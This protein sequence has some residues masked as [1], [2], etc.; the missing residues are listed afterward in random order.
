MIQILK[1]NLSFRKQIIKLSKSELKKTYKGAALGPVWAVIKPAIQIFVFWFAIAVGFRKGGLVHGY[2]FFIFMIT[3]MIPWFFMSESIL[4]GAK[5]IR[6][7]KHFVTKMPFPVGTIMTY[8][9][10]SHLYIHFVLVGIG[11]AIL[12]LSGVMPTIYMIQ[13]LWYLPMMF[14]FFTCLSWITAPLSAVS[15]DFENLVRAILNAIFWLSGIIWDPYAMGDGIV[16][17]IVLLNPVNY[18]ANG[19][20]NVFL[21][22]RWFWETPYETVSFLLLLTGVFFL[23]AFVYKRLRKTLPDV[24]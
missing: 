9:N 17:R 20:R 10:L 24:L 19:Y 14:I 11:L 12:L 5:C 22:K 23:G 2:P 21:Y 18:F 4:E 7:N 13:I 6:M 3:G 16:R 15:K 1:E 8:T